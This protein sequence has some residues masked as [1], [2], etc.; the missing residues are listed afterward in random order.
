MAE[1]E[2]L[3]LIYNRYGSVTKVLRGSHVTSAEF[4]TL[5]KMGLIESTNSGDDWIISDAGRKQLEIIHDPR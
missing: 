2:T 3:H 4:V 5:K 1:G